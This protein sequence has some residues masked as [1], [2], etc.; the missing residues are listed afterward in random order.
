[1]DV[2]IDFAV[3]A[4]GSQSKVVDLTATRFRRDMARART[5]GMLRDV[6]KLWKLGFALGSSL[7]NSVAVDDD[8]ILNPEGLRSSDEFVAHK[9]LDALGDLTLAGAPIL[10]TYRAFCPGHK[11]NYLVLKALFADRSAYE[12]VEGSSRAEPFF[13]D[14]GLSPVSAFASEAS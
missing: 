9:M 13:A 4:I 7:E 10:G 11:M 2:S 12:V 14:F 5:F 1:M 3:A 6:E 8:R